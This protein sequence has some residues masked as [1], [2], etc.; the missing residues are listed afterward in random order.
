M[1]RLVAP[2]RWQHLRLLACVVGLS[3]LPGC[4]PRAV[5]HVF[6]VGANPP[7]IE[8][9]HV[10]LVHNGLTRTVD[11]PPPAGASSISIPNDFAVNLRGRN[12]VDGA[13]MTV[14]VDALRTA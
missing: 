14:T 8:S 9:I 2:R 10:T 4:G 13:D 1:T 12:L 7:G 3:V 11:Y 6:M 5:L